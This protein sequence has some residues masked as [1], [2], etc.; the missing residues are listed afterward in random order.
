MIARADPLDGQVRILIERHLAFGR[1]FTPP[2][3]AHALEVDELI[4]QDIALF[5]AH[6]GQEVVGVGALKE[7]DRH[8]GELKTMH[9]AEAS[10]GRGVGRAILDHLLAEAR[11]RGYR[12]V[13]LETGTMDA[14][15]PARALYESVGFRACEPFGSYRLTRHS[16]YLTLALSEETQRSAGAEGPS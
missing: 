6:E 13:S 16:V 8:H 4:D 12:R 3:F 11:R 2:E 15:A 5:A 14:F 1:A 9:T 10:R 7:L